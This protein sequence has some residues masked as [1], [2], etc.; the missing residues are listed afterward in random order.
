MK[1]L[2]KITIILISITVILSSCSSNNKK[3]NEI[4]LTNTGIE[5]CNSAISTS[6][7][8]NKAVNEQSYDSEYV[9]ILTDNSPETYI[10][11]DLSV[12]NLK[13]NDNLKNLNAFKSLL[14]VY[15][16]YNQ[17]QDKNFSIN[18]SNIKSKLN[19]ACNS[20][21]SIN[22]SEINID[23]L[24][25]LKKQVH[26]NRFDIDYAVFE[27][28]DLYS[29]LW[30][31]EAQ[32]WYLFLE[33][34][35]QE[36]KTGVKKIANS[37]FNINEIAKRLDEPYNNSAVQINLYKLQLIKDKENKK[38]KIEEEINKITNGF[39]IIIQ[40]EAEFLKRRKDNI[41]LKDLNEKLDLLLNS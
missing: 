26:S 2:S 19:A 27:L 21:D 20:L 11:Q 30:E 1:H 9:K 6:Q 16:A 25:R 37:K 18:K 34:S 23:R 5:L 31:D 40:I 36:Y 12:I 39:N 38:I 35:Y 4:I 33:N 3:E 15:I 17:H 14:K 32:K 13:D 8:L 29:D 41:R 10:M 22:L 28:T 24:L 7:M